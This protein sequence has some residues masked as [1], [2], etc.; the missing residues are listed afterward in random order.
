MRL[1][2]V[3]LKAKLKASRKTLDGTR[4]STLMRINDATAE[5]LIGFN[6]VFSQAATGSRKGD[7]DNKGRL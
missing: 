3:V 1:N 2:T 4:Y 5:S 6:K 7:R